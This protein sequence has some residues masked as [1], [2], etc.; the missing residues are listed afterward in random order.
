MMKKIDKKQEKRFEE[1]TKRLK[2][3]EKT[4]APFTEAKKIVE[5]PT[6]SKWKIPSVASDIIDKSQNAS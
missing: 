6:A 1:A 2:E 4:I 3:I 5:I